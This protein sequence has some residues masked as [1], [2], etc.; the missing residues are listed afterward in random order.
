MRAAHSVRLPDLWL[1]RAMA[2]EM[3]PPGTDTSRVQ[4]AWFVRCVKGVDGRA[5]LFNQWLAGDA[6]IR[7]ADDLHLLAATLEL[8]ILN[9]NPS[10]ISTHSAKQYLIENPIPILMAGLLGTFGEFAE[11]LDRLLQRRKDYHEICASAHIQSKLSAV[12][13]REL[14]GTLDEHTQPAGTIQILH[15]KDRDWVGS[16]A[17]GEKIIRRSAKCK[18]ERIAKGDFVQF[19]V[20]P[21]LG[22]RFVF[23]FELRL[24]DNLVSA[25][26]EDVGS[27]LGTRL[28]LSGKATMLFDD[29]VSDEDAAFADVE[30]EFAVRLVSVDTELL[31]D[32]SRICDDLDPEAK[33]RGLIDGCPET[34]PTG[35]A[36]AVALVT[37][38]KRATDRAKR[39]R[40]K[41]E[42]E[43]KRSAAS[44]SYDAA[45]VAEPAIPFLYQGNYVVI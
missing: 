13:R 3:L 40:N 19:V 12:V 7:V 29:P 14:L 30:G 18:T 10:E 5:P 23:G 9:G 24:D 28:Q 37:Y 41:N 22:A 26:W 4:N 21:T 11:S 31:T 2:M 20:A 39:A 42:L 44:I 27:W 43:A 32:F 45:L 38:V 1:K 33:T 36:K 17:A 6:A 8:L 35:Y 25:R 15:G 16:I 34:W